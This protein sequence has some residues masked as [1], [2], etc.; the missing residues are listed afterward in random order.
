MKFRCSFPTALILACVVGGCGSQQRETTP[1]T[2]KTLPRKEQ[3]EPKVEAKVEAKV[4][5]K[6]QETD[7]EKQAFIEFVK[8]NADD[9]SNLEIVRWGEKKDGKR[10]VRFRCAKIGDAIVLDVV[11]PI[12]LDN[13]IVEYNGNQIKQVRLERTYAQLPFSTWRS[14]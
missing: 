3:A 2:T 14:Q 7:P 6:A 11:R 5:P 8:Q 9:P 4:E 10:S 12:M 1:Q 13:C